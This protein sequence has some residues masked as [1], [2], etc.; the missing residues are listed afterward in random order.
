MVWKNV[1]LIQAA[2]PEVIHV[3]MFYNNGTIFDTTFEQSVNIPKLGEHLA[4]LLNQMRR[5]YEVCNFSLENYSKLIVETNDVSIIILKLGEESNIAL[6]FKKEVDETLALKSIKRYIAR[7]EELIDADKFDLLMQEMETKEVILKNLLK[8]L[9][10]KQDQINELKI[11]L[12]TYDE[13]LKHEAKEITKEIGGLEHEYNE[14][15]LEIEFKEKEVK[16]LREKIEE[17]KKKISHE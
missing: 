14:L 8:S 13:T 5:I 11:K 4:E 6:F 15:E 3:A 17:E 1:K 7:I 10:S 2:L 9:I 12:E 16:D